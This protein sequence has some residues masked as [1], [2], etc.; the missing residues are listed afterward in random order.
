MERLSL[1]KKNVFEKLAF[2]WFLLTNRIN[3]LYFTG[4]DG[5]AF[6]LI[7]RDGSNLVYTPKVNFEQAKNQIENSRVLLLTDGKPG[8]KQIVDQ[9]NQLSGLHLGIDFLSARDYLFLR[10]CFKKPITMQVKSDVAMKLR[11]LKDEDELKYLRR[12]GE[13]TC[14]GM[15][16]AKE[17]LQDGMR[18]NDVAA[19]LEYGMRKMGGMGTAFPTIVASGY[20]SA[21]PHAGCSE[22]KIQKGD[23]VTI[24]IGA[25][26]KN[27]VSDMTRTFVVGKASSKQKK[28]INLVN[29]AQ[30]AAY[31]AIRPEIKASLLDSVARN[32]IVQFGYG[33]YFVHSLGHGIGLQVHESP[34]INPKNEAVIVARNVFT[35]EPG[36]Y[37]PGF[38]G[39]RIEDS[40]IV[41]KD[42]V[43]KITKFP[44]DFEC[45]K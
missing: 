16:I 4:F 21:F 23:L 28:I 35:I 36:I 44:Y 39:V 8:L 24:D 2:D 33:D 42:S 37:L 17:M 27:Y 41:K 13:I 20:R 10:K 9:I 22:K 1:L 14:K 18:E 12:A 34:T 26:Y 5:A 15:E 38:G 19:E 3:I 29:S 32:L 7:S 40:I 31:T 43:E 45:Q 6:M 25:I 11:E 30:D